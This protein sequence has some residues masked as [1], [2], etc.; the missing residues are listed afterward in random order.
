MFKAEQLRR[1][2]GEVLERPPQRGALLGRRLAAGLAQVER[3]GLDH[4][5]DDLA[6]EH[7]AEGK[8]QGVAGE[9]LEIAVDARVKAFGVQRRFQVDAQRD[10]AGAFQRLADGRS[11]IHDDR[12]GHA[13]RREIHLAEA[14]VGLRA[15]GRERETH[16]FE[17]EPRH[18][19]VKALGC[20]HGTERRTRFDD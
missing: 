20:L 11:H 18:S 19:A 6:G 3:G 14:L 9:L 13:E 12:A 8:P 1:R 15:V 17:L 10:G 2:D 5:R 4:F 16:V 7:F